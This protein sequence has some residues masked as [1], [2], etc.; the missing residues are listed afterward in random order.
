MITLILL[1][2]FI[3]YSIL[4]FIINNNWLLVLYI[5]IEL[6][7]IIHYKINIY[8][9][10]TSLKLYLPVLILIFLF[11]LFFYNILSSL[12]ISFKILLICNASFILSTIISITDLSKAL[13]ILLSPLKL[14]KYDTNNLVLTIS[15]ALTFI[16]ILKDLITN[17]KKE[18]IVRNFK[19]NFK[20]LITKPNIFL[21]TYLYQIFYKINELDKCLTSRLFN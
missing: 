1:L 11:N 8:E 15:L 12:L 6:L 18:L 17:I 3:P 9:L 14:F 16:P 2:A 4:L 5:L 21:K 19:L 13:S 20:N 7:F 10:L